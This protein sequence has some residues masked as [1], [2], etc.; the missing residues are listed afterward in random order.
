MD[1]TQMKNGKIV[2]IETDDFFQP[3]QDRSRVIRKALTTMNKTRDV[4]N[5]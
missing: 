1:L 2:P 3:D 5:N 4:R